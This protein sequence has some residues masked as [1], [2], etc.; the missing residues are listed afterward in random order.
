[1]LWS[2]DNAMNYSAQKVSRYEPGF[3]VKHSS[4]ILQNILD[5]FRTISRITKSNI[6]KFLKLAYLLKL[7]QKKKTPHQSYI[8]LSHFCKYP[9]PTT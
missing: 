6:F 3:E 5:K 2:M 8:P 1:M 9:G 4:K 7:K